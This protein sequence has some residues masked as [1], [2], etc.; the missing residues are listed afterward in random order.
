MR[1]A[2]RSRRAS[3]EAVALVPTMGALHEGH[4][5]LVDRARREAGFV[6]V[7]VFVNPTQFG[8][9][10]DYDEY[11]RDLE[12]D[13]TLA[14]EHGVDLVFAPPVS[15][16]YPREPEVWVVPGPMGRRLDGRSRPDHFRG[17]LTVVTK[18]F[19]IVEPQVAVFGRKDFMQ[20]V[21]VRRL[22]GDLDI[23]VEIDVAPV[24][25][26]EDGLAVSSRNAY[27]S[28]DERRRARSLSEALRTV[29]RAYGEGQRSAEALLEPADSILSEADA[30]IDYLE[31]V[32]P[33]DLRS[34][35]DPVPEEA[36]CVV[37]AWI[38]DT[39]LIDNAPVGGPS[40]LGPPL[41][42]PGR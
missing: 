32:D 19:Q 36:V 31:I 3:G 34:V 22:V 26:E 21:L 20:A 23:P 5:S 6:V 4:L 24:V 9:D 30:R 17:V 11:P 41:A 28:A 15:E 2:S 37:A 12:R 8:P 40:S 10:E 14:G 1:S 13:L 25:R 42:G 16:M 18:L 29:R 33:A 7:S 35:S 27:L 38:G 39:R